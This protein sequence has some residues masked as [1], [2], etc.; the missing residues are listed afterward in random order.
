MSEKQQPYSGNNDN[1]KLKEN[2]VKKMEVIIIRT[3][4]PFT[5]KFDLIMSMID[6]YKS[7]N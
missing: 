1:E 5:E 6:E 4:I 7:F 2:I 3:D